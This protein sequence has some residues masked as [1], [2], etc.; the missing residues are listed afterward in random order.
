MEHRPAET[1]HWQPAGSE[2]FTG[3][4]W[5]G[6]I[7][8]SVDPAGLNVLGVAFEPGARSDWHTHPAGQVLYIVS[9]S[10]RVQSEGGETVVAGP[11]DAVV[12]APGEIHWHGAGPNSPMVHLS[13]TDGGPTEWLPRKVTDAE[14]GD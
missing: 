11:G 6:P 7:Q 2:H 14:Y 4:V 12:A 13:I 9:G 3:R 5:F 1:T 10:A 8:P